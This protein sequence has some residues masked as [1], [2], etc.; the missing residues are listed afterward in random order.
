MTGTGQEPKTTALPYLR[1]TRTTHETDVSVVIDAISILVFL[2]LLGLG[3][4]SVQ[5][6]HKKVNAKDMI[7]KKTKKIHLIFFLFF[8][9]LFKKIKFPTHFLSCPIQSSRIR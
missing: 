8:R 1:V 5:T 4:S 9:L 2:F 6:S 3:L 7:I